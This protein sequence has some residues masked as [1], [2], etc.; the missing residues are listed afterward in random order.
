[1]LGN[2]S[3][4]F[5]RVTVRNRGEF[6]S[7]MVIFSHS[8]SRFPYHADD[9]AILRSECRTSTRQIFGALPCYGDSHMW[10]E[11]KEREIG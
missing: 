9:R 6:S 2:F 7:P 11:G 4:S 10:N 1:M 8:L 3:T 5:G